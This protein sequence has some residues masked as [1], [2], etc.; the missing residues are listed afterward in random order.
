VIY[1]FANDDRG[2]SVYAS[3]EEA[4]T[5]CEGIDVEANN[6]RFFSVTGQALR[7]RA[8]RPSQSTAV[9]IVSAEYSLEPDDRPAT[10]GL[11]AILS[12][13]SYVEGCG[14]TNVGDVALELRRTANVTT[15]T[16]SNTSLER[17]RQ[18]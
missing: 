8:T 5:A 12:D 16:P 4:I 1:V 18:G 10:P 6:Y 9:G 7:P 15:Q 13:V 3:Q 17:T 2:L 14:L 11:T